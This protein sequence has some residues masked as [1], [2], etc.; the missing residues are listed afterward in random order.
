MKL[1][2][3][4]PVLLTSL[5]LV[6]CGGKE[7]KPTPKPSSDELAVFKEAVRNSAVTKVSTSETYYVPS[8]SVTLNASSVLT[9]S[10]NDGI[11]AKYD[12][13]FQKLG[14]ASSS[15]FIENKSGTLYANALSVGEIKNAGLEWY[16]N[17]SKSCT[18]LGFNLDES[19]F[20][21]YSVNNDSNTLTATIN[22]QHVSSFL[23]YDYS[24]VTNMLF[25]MTLNSDKKVSSTEVDFSVNSN[26]VN[27]KNLYSYEPQIVVIQ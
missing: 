27:V 8:Y 17:V 15:S 12:Y 10:Y 2:K 11:L 9:I 6:A 14:D 4:I 5:T 1:F 21:S 18:L 26:K 7:E 20:S 16:D 13:A 25:R 22:D 19:Y 23:N 24:G 3:I